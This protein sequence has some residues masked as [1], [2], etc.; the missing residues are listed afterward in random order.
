[1][2]IRIVIA[3]DHFIVRKG[4]Q[5]LVAEAPDVEIAGEATDGAEA[6]RLVAD[7]DPDIVLMDLVMP[8]VDGVTAIRQILDADPERRIIVLTGS[9]T[10]REILD[11]VRAG[12]LGYLSKNAS[13]EACLRAIRQVDRGE[14]ALPISITRRLLHRA[15]AA[16][17][18]GPESDPLTPRETEVLGLVARGLDDREIGD[19]LCISLA[20]V[21]THVSN[22]LAKLRLKN[23]VEAALYALR[24][25]LVTLEEEEDAVDA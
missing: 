24:Q 1:M 13:P 3:D 19:R 23:R 25:G 12:A 6:V 4:I 17:A 8:G 5:A 7:L 11:A 14:A 16:A 21:R 9:G 20:T 10:E 22:F 2:T 15:G 18:P